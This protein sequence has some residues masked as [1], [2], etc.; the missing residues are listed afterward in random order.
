MKSRIFEAMLVLVLVGF[1]WMLPVPD[2]IYNYRTTVRADHFTVDTIEGQTTTTL[3][4]F[5]PVYGGDPE[6]ISASSN[7]TSD[8]PEIASYEPSTRAVTVSGLSE[9]EA[10]RL[11]ISYDTDA[12]TQSRSISSFLDYLPWLWIINLFA[13]PIC[14]IIVVIRQ[15]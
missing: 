7:S 10:H 11:E 6:K 3:V 9:S 5:K 14:A 13:F 1:L 15:R 4:L 2:A 8:S 12:L